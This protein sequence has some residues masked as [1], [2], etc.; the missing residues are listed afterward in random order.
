VKFS[1]SKH[2]PEPVAHGRA[3]YLKYLLHLQ[4]HR[5]DKS[6]KVLIIIKSNGAGQQTPACWRSAAP[7]G[8]VFQILF[9]SKSFE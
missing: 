1:S 9:E 8:Y 6:K 4:L 2:Q 5:V 7:V 3:F